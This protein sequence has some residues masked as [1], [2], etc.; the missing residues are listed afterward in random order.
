[1]SSTPTFQGDDPVSNVAMPETPAHQMPD[2]PWYGVEAD[3]LPAVGH[4][5]A[6]GLRVALATLVHVEGSSPRPL[7]SEMAIAET[8]ACVGYV[9][10]G[11][12][13]AAVVQTALECLE[14]GSPVLL[15]YGA[16]SPVLDLQLSCGGRIHIFVR[17][18]PNIPGFLAEQ[19]AARSRRREATVLTD[20]STG[21][22]QIRPGKQDSSPGV[23]A[24]VVPIPLR[25]VVV[26]ADPVALAV[27]KQASQ[28]GFE[29]EMVRPHGPVS[30]PPHL[31]LA[32][33]H[34]GALETALANLV[35]DGRTAVYAFTHDDAI[36]HAVLAFALDNHAFAAGALGSRRKTGGRIGRL[37][38]DGF[39]ADAVNALF[40]PAGVKAPAATAP[41][42]IATTIVA[43]LLAAAPGG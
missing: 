25:L 34:A 16:G 29:V 42:Q 12:V 35:V 13:E 38:D 20:L 6:C 4:W 40:L 43:Q 26:G 31:T 18:L 21:S 39:S 9:S 24:Q 22:W 32:G 11:C 33:Y 37:L 7:G 23:F 5:H 17:Q 30:R 19:H 8:G 28:A 41:R 3:V 36:D 2:W 1:L 15:D 27:A 10:G 14:S